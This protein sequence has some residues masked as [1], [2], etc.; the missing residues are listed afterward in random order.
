MQRAPH[1]GHAN[2]QQTNSTA[3]TV[4]GRKSRHTTTN[5]TKSTKGAGTCTERLVVVV[6]S[7]SGSV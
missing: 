3:T 1:L 7:S 5:K 4:P 6:S 2:N